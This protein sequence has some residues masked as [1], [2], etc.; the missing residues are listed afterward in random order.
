M[1]YARPVHGS[2]LP[3]KTV[4]L[5]FDDGPGESAEDGPGPNSL[6]IAAYLAREGVPATFFMVGNCILQY[7][8][9]PG[10]IAALGHIVGNHTFDHSKP[11][12][13]LFQEGADL[14]AE[15]SRTDRLIRRLPG[16]DKRIYFRA[17]WGEWSA[18]VA[19]LLNSRYPDAADYIGP[20]HWD[21]DTNDWRC[22]R[23]GLDAD[24]CARQSLSAI[25]STGRGIILMHDSS[26][27]LPGARAMNRTL[28][29]VKILI[30]HL[31]EQGYR[32]ATLAE[33][34]A[35]S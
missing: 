31:K 27:D 18:E 19:T 7:P 11:L 22:W 24:A 12:P 32:F 28:A 34:P 17:P 2:S 8:H 9:L 14:V 5:T 26:A 1:F 29:T 6:A 13:L 10:K 30:P 20:I 23:D 25:A 16:N 4:C 35:D 21:I 3:E 33:I 15:I